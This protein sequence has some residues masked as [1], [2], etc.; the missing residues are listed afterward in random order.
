M[1]ITIHYRGTMDDVDQVEAMEDR[2]L[3]LVFSLGGRATIWRSY[4]DDDHDRVVRGL[5]I[6]MEPGQDTF[7]LLVSP[8]GHLTPLFQI[9]EAEKTPFQEPPYC[10]VKTQFGSLQGHIAIVH[11]LDAI[12]QNYCSNLEVTDEGEYYEDR[13]IHK[14]S[15]KMQFLRSAISSMAEGLREHGLSKE[16][17]EDPNI[18]ATRIER[19]A[20]LVQEK[21]LAPGRESGLG[22]QWREPSGSPETNTDEIW[23]DPSLDEEVETMDRLRRQNDLRSERMARRIAEA[24]ASGLSAEEAFELAMQEEGLEPLRSSSNETEDQTSDDHESEQWWLESVPPHPFE[25]ASEKARRENHPAVEQAQAFLLAVMDLAKND[26]IKSSFVSVLTRASMDIVGGLVQATSDDLHD[27]IHRALAITQLKRA[28]S[29][30]AY[31]RGAIFGLRSEQTINQEQ[32]EE[33]HRQLESLLTTIHE[34]VETAWSQ[35]D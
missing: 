15:Q 35:S 21:M 31:A 17:A 12:R 22:S 9:E 19:I 25:E 5:M 30:H 26:T 32:S 24:T 28:L 4:A 34:L 33:F 6:E 13:D 14:L 23:H 11:L 8:E 27:N 16:A 20:A 2:V 29:A 3:D 7:S 1:G 18:L 10:F